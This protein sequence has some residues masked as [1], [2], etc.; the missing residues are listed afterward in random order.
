MEAYFYELYLLAVRISESYILSARFCVGS[1][2]FFKYN[3]SPLTLSVM[4]TDT[5]NDQLNY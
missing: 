4:I 2:F 1:K 5:D 3:S